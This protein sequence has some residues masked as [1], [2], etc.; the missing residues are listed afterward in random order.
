MK[1]NSCFVCAKPLAQL[2]QA[3]GTTMPTRWHKRANTVAQTWHSI[4]EFK[5][6]LV[7]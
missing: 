7:I 6:Y 3:V 4:N 5:A 1:G 2:C